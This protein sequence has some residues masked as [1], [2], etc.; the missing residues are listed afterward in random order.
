M[1]K[2]LASFM[3]VALIFVL[4]FGFV[5][6]ASSVNPQGQCGEG[7]TG[8]VLYDDHYRVVG[9]IDGYPYVV[10]VCKYYNT[11]NL[12]LTALEFCYLPEVI[13]G[14]Y[15]IYKA[16]INENGDYICWIDMMVEGHWS[17]PERTLKFRASN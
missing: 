3:F 5:A 9:E 16:K 10:D 8:T 7:I 17:E 4:L 13:N 6:N 1:N 15:R 2:I 12:T 11:G 14:W